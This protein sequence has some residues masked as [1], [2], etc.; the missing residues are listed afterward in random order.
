ME[1]IQYS[2]NTLAKRVSLDIETR[3]FNRAFDEIMDEAGLNANL[4]RSSNEQP[5]RVDFNRLRDSSNPAGLLAGKELFAVRLTRLNTTL[6]KTL[7][8]SNAKLPQRTQRDTLNA[9]FSLLSDPRLPMIG[10]SRP[11]LTRAED[12]QGRSLLT[13]E[14]ENNNLS[15]Y[16]FYSNNR[17]SQFGLNLRAPEPDA[18]VLRR[19]EGVVV[20]SLVTKTETWE[21]PDVLSAPEWK[22]SFK[23]GAQEFEVTVKANSVKTAGTTSERMTLAVEVT[24]NQ[25][26]AGQEIPPPLLAAMPVVAALRVVDAKG[27]EMRLSQNSSNYSGDE[28]KMT[29]SATI[30]PAYNR[31]GGETKTPTLPL[32][33][34]FQAPLSVVQTEAPFRLRERAPAM[35]PAP[36]PG[37]IKG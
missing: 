2:K 19:L 3:S 15:P 27:G 22:R 26:T 4:Q 23:N 28:G 5:W 13:G 24:S 31:Y 18:K 6:S 8:L 16:S 7:D 30:Y 33:M 17:Q 9:S 21:V 1:N 12:E 34:I 25:R 20:H 29:V 14:E 10:L 11:R 35:T 32:K 36:Q 37:W